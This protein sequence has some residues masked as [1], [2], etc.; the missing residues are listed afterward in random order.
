MMVAIRRRDPWRF[1][2]D[3]NTLTADFSLDADRWRINVGRVGHDV[4][5][6]A[7]VDI[8][9]RTFP[10]IRLTPE[11]F[12][13]RV[14][15]FAGDAVNPAAPAKHLRGL[16]AYYYIAPRNNAVDNSYRA[17]IY[18]WPAPLQAW[19]IRVSYVVKPQAKYGPRRITAI[20]GA[21]G[22]EQ[23]EVELNE[24]DSTIA[25]DESVRQ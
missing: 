6:V 8:R 15:M 10:L 19:R 13:Q 14:G 11:A 24:S 23:D 3:P 12:G 18:L 20:I 9:G 21:P 22:A 1:E 17:M 5:G 4:I 7:L 16:P 25:G 2:F